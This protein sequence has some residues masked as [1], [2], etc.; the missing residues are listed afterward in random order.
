MTLAGLLAAAEPALGV[1]R[2][3]NWSV[4]LAGRNYPVMS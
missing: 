4:W 2:A 3:T 1:R